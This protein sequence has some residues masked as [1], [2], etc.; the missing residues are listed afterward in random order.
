MDGPKLGPEWFCNHRT[1]RQASKN[2]RTLAADNDA[3]GV[4]RLVIPNGPRMMIGSR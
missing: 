3:G 2:Q 4:C 1:Q